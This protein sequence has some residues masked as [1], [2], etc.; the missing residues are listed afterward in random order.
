MPSS[1]ALASS[2]VWLHQGAFPWLA[3][4]T[5]QLVTLFALSNLW[6]MQKR[7]LVASVMRAVAHRAPVKARN[8]VESAEIARDGRKK[9]SFFGLPG[10]AKTEVEAISDLP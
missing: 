9:P 3:K 4:N 8:R 6:M 5:A 2:G 10:R 7:L 1:Q